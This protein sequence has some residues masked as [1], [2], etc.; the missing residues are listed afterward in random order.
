MNVK[1]E[2]FK[3]LSAVHIA[4]F[5]ATGGRIGGHL[6]GMDA[7]LLTTTGRKTG[8][9]RTRPL[10]APIVEDERIVLVASYGGDTRHPA[11]YLNLSSNPEVTAET[12]RH[13]RRQMR[14]RTATAEEKA[15][16]W[17]GIVETYQGYGGYQER[18][19]RDIPLVILTPLD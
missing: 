12:R 10:T 19:D 2:A 15:E 9:H 3:V 14:A 5:R 17:P 7:V 1:D 11:W 4:L 8:Q 16:L 13:G 6:G 18:T